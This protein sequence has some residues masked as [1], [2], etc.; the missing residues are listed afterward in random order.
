V[1]ARPHARSTTEINSENNLFPHRYFTEHLLD[2]FRKSEQFKPK[3]LEIF[4]P[5]TQETYRG[6][7]A[8]IHTTTV[9][10]NSRSDQQVVKTH[11]GKT[12]LDPALPRRQPGRKGD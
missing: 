5:T 8:T 9:N 10:P 2:V 12:E 6:S 4:D 1:L 11:S 7:P 3:T